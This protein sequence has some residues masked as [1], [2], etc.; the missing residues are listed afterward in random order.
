MVLIDFF[1][2]EKFHNLLAKLFFSIDI[3]I[4]SVETVA[5]RISRLSGMSGNIFKEGTDKLDICEYPCGN[6][7]LGSTLSNL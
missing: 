6:Y 2:L 5:E 7:I 1:V 4:Y 3:Q